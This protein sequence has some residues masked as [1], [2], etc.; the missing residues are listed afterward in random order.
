M[1]L[2]QFVEAHTIVQI[3]RDVPG[4][5]YRELIVDAPEALVSLVAES[6]GYISGILWWEWTPLDG[7]PVLGA[8]G[9]ADPRNPGYFFA[10]TFLSEEFEETASVGE[11][12]AYLREVQSHHCDVR[13]YPGFDI[14]CP[15][16]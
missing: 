7:T 14:V 2:S 16:E 1:K 13:L 4:Y 3:G 9:V 15:G 8:G 6:G 12:L 11:I 5:P 10:E